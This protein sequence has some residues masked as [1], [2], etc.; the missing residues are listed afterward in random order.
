M[1][2]HECPESYYIVWDWPAV[3]D[4]VLDIESEGYTA[5]WILGV[6][7]ELYPSKRDYID[8]Y[9][10]NGSCSRP[11]YVVYMRVGE[12]GEPTPEG[13]FMSANTGGSCVGISSNYVPVEGVTFEGNLSYDYNRFSYPTNEGTITFYFDN[14]TMISE[15]IDTSSPPY[16]TSVRLNGTYQATIGLNHCK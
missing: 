12:D 16:F 14:F 8:I 10:A 7:G 6:R 2:C 13:I 4:V 5:D 9:L 15:G 3:S 11:H 1:S